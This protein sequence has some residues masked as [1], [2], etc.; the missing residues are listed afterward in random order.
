[1]ANPPDD[2]KADRARGPQETAS[3]TTGGSLRADKSSN[4]RTQN[5]ATNASAKVPTQPQSLVNVPLPFTTL[6]RYTVLRELGRGGMGTVYLAEDTMLKRQVA[7]KI[8]QFEPGKSE[9]M[10][11]R[12]VREAQMAASLSHPNICQVFDVAVIDS[13]HVMAMEYIDGRT[14]SAYTKPDKLL[15]ERQAVQLVKKVALAVEAA[16][17]KKMI[18]R[19]L[20]PGNIMLAKTDASR[21]SVEPKV[22]DFGLAKSLG[23]GGT[24]LTKSGMIIGTP[25]YMSKEQWS[26]KDGQIG[27]ASDVYSLG[28]I[29]YE[30]LTGKLPY[31]VDDDEPA[32]AWFVRLVTRDQ[33]PPREHKHGLDAGLESIVMRSIAIEAED[34]YGTM[35]EF[36]KALDE[37]L[38]GTPLA[39]HG[40]QF[41][42]DPNANEETDAEVLPL[43]NS[44]KSRESMSRTRLSRSA[45]IRE[46]SASR[47]SPNAAG[48]AGKFFWQGIAGCGLVGSFVLWLLLNPNSVVDT[49]VVTLSENKPLIENPIESQ[50]EL[51]SAPAPSATL[52]SSDTSSLPTDGSEVSDSTEPALE[53]NVAPLPSSDDREM[54]NSIG[55]KLKLIPPG[56]FVMGSNARR[57]DLESAGF[58]FVDKFDISNERPAHGVRITKSFFMG[59]HEVTYGQFASFVNATN[60]RTE[61]ELDGQGGGGGDAGG[62]IVKLPQ[63]NWT[64]VG[65][66]QSDAHPVT[67]VSWNDANAFIQWLSDTEGKQY[68]LPT[69]AEWEYCCRAGSVTHF[70]SGDSQA[71][72]KGFANVRDTSCLPND[73]KAF[74]PFPFDDGFVYASPVGSFKPNAFGLFDMH[75]N[76]WELCQ[77]AY[78]SASYNAQVGTVSDPLVESGT[79]RASR[80]GSWNNSGRNVRS[81]FRGKFPPSYRFY[82]LGFRVALNASGE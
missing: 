34:R 68:R 25:C 71:S 45:R 58:V 59:V 82:G 78:D 16:H 69:E 46:G 61:A 73:D 27:P 20:K 2:R 13:R 30:L 40:S 6:G 21:K 19:D 33:A 7:L 23:G 36:T 79:H 60:Y 31:D 8:P 17:Q 22:M 49:Y 64:S 81:A 10:Q 54:V 32:T 53:V 3:R 37:W 35:A 44:T 66:Y 51:N 12:F 50:G 56:E 42:A 4:P 65:M 63:Y 39:T 15:P 67:N 75:G 52:N 80:G 48:V 62:G 38:Q 57:E 70:S 29:L 11:A 14:L 24:E 1:M 76:M 9:Q 18:H 74:P 47:R 55:M 41:G 72:L 77:D 5:T 43:H 26:A 28:M